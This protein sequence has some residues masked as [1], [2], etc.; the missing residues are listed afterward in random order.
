MSL[1]PSIGG[2]LGARPERIAEW[3][4]RNY[5]KWQVKTIYHFDQ[6]ARLQV[7]NDK[8]EPEKLREPQQRLSQSIRDE[9]LKEQ[10]P[11]QKEFFELRGIVQGKRIKL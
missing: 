2:S 4:V 5:V 7:S 11:Q 1:A 9:L 10:T 8:E 6:P 3:P